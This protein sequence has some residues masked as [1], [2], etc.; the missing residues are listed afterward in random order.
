MK[1]LA[2][3][4]AAAGALAAVTFIP[5]VASAGHGWGGHGWG[6]HGW[7]GRGWHGG[8]G[9]GPGWGWGWGRG[10]RGWGWGPGVGIA[11]GPGYYGRRCW[12]N[13]YGWVPCRW[14][15]RY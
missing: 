8:H 2:I 9:W 15:Y 11:I 4:I 10:W 14:A 3:V 1:R 6:G 5:N 13:R 7:G 12:S